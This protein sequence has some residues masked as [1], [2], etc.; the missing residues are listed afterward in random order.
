MKQTSKTKNDVLGIAKQ[1]RGNY[2]S[3]YSVSSGSP[4]SY[5]WFLINE[6]EVKLYTA[7]KTNKKRGEAT[8]YS[9]AW[10]IENNLYIKNQKSCIGIFLDKNTA[11]MDGFKNIY[12][13]EF[14]KV[15]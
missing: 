7:D 6:N 8:T 10:T 14:I 5:Y 12:Y 13:S 9:D 3:K 1:Y 4:G 15:G 2:R 11:Y